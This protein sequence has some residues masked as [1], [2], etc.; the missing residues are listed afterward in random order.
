MADF[1]AKKMIA[2]K[3]QKLPSLIHNTTSTSKQNVENSETKRN[4]S[5][6]VFVIQ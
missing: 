4:M 6:F 5:Y 1:G 3:F 2:K